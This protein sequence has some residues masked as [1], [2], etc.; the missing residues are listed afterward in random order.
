MTEDAVI[1]SSEHIRLDLGGPGFE[2]K[3]LAQTEGYLWREGHLFHFTQRRNSARHIASAMSALQVREFN[4]VPSGEGLC[5][6]GSFFADPREGDPGEAVRF[7]ID[8]PAA[9]PMLLNFETVTLLSAEQQAG[10]KPGE[11][12][13]LFD[14]NK[15]F[16]GKV[17]R[18][19]R[20]D[21]AGRP[22]REM[23][24]AFTAKEGGTYQTSIS[25]QWFSPGEVGG[26]AKLPHVKIKLEVGYAS[27]EEPAK[28]A[29]FP[30]SDESGRSPEAK[31]M[32]LWQAILDGTRLR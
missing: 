19:R 17:L 31:F 32:G 20:R 14:G 7:A 16:Q 11:P 22:G 12:D 2:G 10:L 6:A 21:V 4:I 13:F 8:I 27:R 24:S 1:F 30:D 9:P 15:D 3:E 18:E 28:W 5:S 26:G 25:A 23:I 29:A